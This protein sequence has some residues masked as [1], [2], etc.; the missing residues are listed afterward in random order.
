MADVHQR[1]CLP[2][3]LRIIPFAC[4]EHIYLL[5]V[6]RP[7]YLCIFQNNQYRSKD[8][9][10]NLQ[11]IFHIT[12]RLNAA[13]PRKRRKAVC[14]KYRRSK[15][16]ARTRSTPWLT[17]PFRCPKA[18]LDGFRSDIWY[19]VQCSSFELS[20]QRSISLN[21]W[22]SWQSTVVS[23]THVPRCFPTVGRKC[24]QREIAGNAGVYIIVSNNK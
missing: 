19:S 23:T 15:N 6:C 7:V 16:N 12:N 17:R 11:G 14:Q 1:S 13:S 2:F 5:H 22:S 18:G 8:F 20:R 24:Q 21:L 10:I 4:K 9:L 3:N